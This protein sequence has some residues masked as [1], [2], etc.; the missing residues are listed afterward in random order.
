MYWTHANGYSRHHDETRAS[1]L[2]CLKMRSRKSEEALKRKI[3][4][5]CK[6]IASML[7]EKRS[8]N[9]SLC[10]MCVRSNNNL[11]TFSII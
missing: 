5:E 6:T 2:C 9:P 3:I 1:T 4:D 11:F 8:N 10:L 7:G